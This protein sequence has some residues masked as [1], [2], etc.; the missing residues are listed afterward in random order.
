MG[1]LLIYILKFVLY[2][3]YDRG[4][5]ILSAI[6]SEFAFFKLSCMA[7]KCDHF[8]DKPGGIS[9]DFITCK[10]VTDFG[11]NFSTKKLLYRMSESSIS[12]KSRQ[13]NI[14][15]NWYMVLFFRLYFYFSVFCSIFP[16]AFACSIFCIILAMVSRYCLRSASIRVSIIPLCSFRNPFSRLHIKTINKRVN[17]RPVEMVS[18]KLKKVRQTGTHL[19]NTQSEQSGQSK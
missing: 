7:K 12:L 3:N 15:S 2:P 19:L 5:I 10:K 13:T 4:A 14:L 18:D 11:L 6:Y 1:L 8:P 17:G 9:Y 16:E